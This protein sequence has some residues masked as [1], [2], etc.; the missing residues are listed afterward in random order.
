MFFTIEGK[1]SG[2]V[3]SLKTIRGLGLIFNID[4]WERLPNGDLYIWGTHFSKID[5][6]TSLSQSINETI[7]GINGH[8]CISNFT[9]IAERSG[10]CLAI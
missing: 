5:N 1:I 2:V 6:V 7:K 9:I 3:S 8:N 10:K 4:D